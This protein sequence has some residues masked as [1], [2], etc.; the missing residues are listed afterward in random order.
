MRM[1]TG[2]DLMAQAARS[3]LEPSGNT[4]VDE[5]RAWMRVGYNPPPSYKGRDGVKIMQ[6]LVAL[7]IPLHQH[8]VAKQEAPTDKDL[9]DALAFAAKVKRGPH[10]GSDH[11]HSRATPGDM[12]VR[13]RLN[14]CRTPCVAVSDAV[15]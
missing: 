9:T 5:A 15:T 4:L 12:A 8:D 14:L 13:G 1:S 10:G 7:L 6:D 3:E 2:D 11:P